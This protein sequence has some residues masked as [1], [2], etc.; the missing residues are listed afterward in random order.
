MIDCIA[1]RTMKVKRLRIYIQPMTG[2]VYI[3]GRL[4]LQRWVHGMETLYIYQELC[5][6][7]SFLKQPR[8][9]NYSAFDFVRL[10]AHSPFGPSPS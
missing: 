10:V 7:Y 4:M 6:N 1:N 2:L 5:A 8:T 3:R 9:T